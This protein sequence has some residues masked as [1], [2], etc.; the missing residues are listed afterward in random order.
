MCRCRC[1]HMS[2]DD[3]SLYAAHLSPIV[4]SGGGLGW[5]E[6][7]DAAIVALLHDKLSTG[8]HDQSIASNANS[9]L[10]DCDKLKRHVTLMLERVERLHCARR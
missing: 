1:P 3:A 10:E 6:Q 8:K 4:A 9:A 7:T 2:D 5:E